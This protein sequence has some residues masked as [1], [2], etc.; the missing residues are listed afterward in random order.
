VAR[1][2]NLKIERKVEE[3]HPVDVLNDAAETARLLVVG[4]HGRGAFRRLLL[5]SVSHELLQEPALPTMVVR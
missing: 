2:P 4:S 1:Y 3:G 5:G